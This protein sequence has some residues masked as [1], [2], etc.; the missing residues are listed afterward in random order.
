[1]TGLSAFGRNRRRFVLPAITL[2]AG[3][4]LGGA[5]LPARG[6][7]PGER[8]APS[9]GYY[10]AF[11]AFYEGDYKDALKIFLKEGRGA[12]KTP[13]SHWI[14]SICYHTM[15]GE[16]YYQMG[17]LP[18]AL[19]HYTSALKLYNA[20]SGWMIKV[21]FPARV[22]AAG[23]GAYRAVPWGASKR[24][25][26]LGQYPRKMPIAQGRIDNNPQF[27][28]GGVVQPAMLFPIQVQEI[29]RSTTLAIRRRAEL[30]GPVCPHDP[31]TAELIT[32]LSRRPG[33]PNHWSECWVDV[34]LGLALLAGGQEQQAIPFLQRSLLAAGEFDHPLTCV[35]LL[36]LGR[37]A[38]AKGQY[39]AA[40][41][42]LE[43]STYSAAAYGDCGVLEEAFRYGTIAHM[44]GGGN[45]ICPLLQPA[46]RWAKVKDLRQLRASLLLLAAENHAF[47]GQTPQAAAAL[48]DEARLALGRRTMGAGR[49]GARL[50]YLSAL[51]LFQ[52]KKI[53]AGNDA[54]AAA[55]GYMRHG[56][57]WLFQIGLAD[58]LY[59]GGRAS[60]RV[61]MDLYTG[62]L[63][64]PQPTDWTLQPMESLAVLVTPHPIPMEHWFEVALLRKDH[65]TALEISERVRRHRFFSSLA[66]GGRL[67]SLRWILEAPPEILPKQAQLQRQDLLAQHPVYDNL[68]QQARAIRNKLEAMPLV[69][70]DQATQQEQA[71]LM[72][73]LAAVS[74]LQEA[75]LRE[76]A[77]RREPSSLVFP[78]LKTTKEILEGLP[79]GQA[80]LVFFAT[81]RA[82][83]GFLL[84]DQRYTYWQLRSSPLLA[85][86]LQAM[87]RDM[88]HFEQNRELSLK[89]LAD[90]KWKQPA[91][92]LLG[93]LLEGSRADLAQ[94]DELVIVPDGLLWY[95]PFEA[96][97]QKVGDKLEPLIL[98]LRIRYAPTASLA[99]PDGRARKPTGNAVV[100]AGKLFP[101]DDPSVAQA[102]FEQ[103]ARVV[104]GAVALRGPLPGP[105]SVYATLFDRLVVLDDIVSMEVGPYGWAPVQIERN[106]PGNTLGDWLS[107]PWGGPDVVVLPGFHTAAE[108]SLKRVN[109]AAPGMEVFL[110][111]CGLMA[112][113][114]RTL[115]ISR[116]RTGGQNSFDLV[117]EFTQELPHT[118]PADAWQRAVLLTAG[119]PIDLKAEP[120]IKRADDNQTAPRANHPFFWAG[121]ML[122]DSGVPA[123][124][125]DPKPA[126]A[127]A[128]KQP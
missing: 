35:A 74:T 85:K 52:Q 112:D 38:L 116:W 60:P 125:P 79:K 13:Q 44:L 26:R 100:V 101:R 18:Q 55:M 99:I 96:L 98:R 30:M 64:D 7:D 82:T 14:D 6:Q 71:K 120:R 84:A 61:A 59:T 87:L 21:Q 97:Q 31:I 56:S 94:I 16:C 17:D 36:E 78:P 4:L 32:N 49:I 107:L 50:S 34:Q 77:L 39:P 3:S 15:V 88:G 109:R 123:H 103:F 86:Q 40:A 8:L 126:P 114:A 104:P 81:S 58:G 9:A 29:V 62:V 54:L 119:S 57:H 53:P 72:G 10:A 22:T 117:R 28:Q 41:R 108:A 80:L 70:D 115:L 67:E 111:V 47:F 124:K 48:L 73:Q 106:K 37:V 102:A 92:K 5:A 76:V 25:A 63:R 110:S 2:V 90:S 1:M 43:E 11:G 122:I 128:P 105:T 12:I 27:R 24:N 33:P 68:A 65:E 75:L 118:L 42:L 113:G 93:M 83:Y 69:P 89:D 66:F 20:F 51:V 127:P 19:E 46:A 95:V 121:Y 91:E 23:R 45:G